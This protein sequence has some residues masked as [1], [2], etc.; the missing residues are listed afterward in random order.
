MTTRLFDSWPEQYNRW[1][2]TPIGALIKEYEQ[3]LIVD[4]LQPR[5]NEL[6][7][8]VGCGTGVFTQAVVAQGAEVVGLDISESMLRYAR[9]ALPTAS[10]KPVVANMLVLPFSDARFDKTL[11]VTALEFVEDAGVAMDELFRVTR[12]SGYV[13]V[14]TLN[15]LSPWANRRGTEAHTNEHSVFKHAVFRS[16]KQLRSLA[17][18]E[19]LVK[20]A[21]HFANDTDPSLAR[22]I[23]NDGQ[24]AGLDTGAFVIGCWQKPLA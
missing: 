3:N 6:I 16:P 14:A 18:V 11:S 13:V 21:I 8:D 22:A 1:F 23:E 24:K 5:P 10:L 9:R 20:T 4:L 12:P 2:E 7:L 19:G 17:P 15:S